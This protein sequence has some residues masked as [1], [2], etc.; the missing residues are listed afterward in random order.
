MKLE[1]SRQIFEKY[2]GIKFNQNP[3]SGS[4]VGPR[5][6]TDE[7]TDRQT[8]M[9]KQIVDFRNF[10]NAPKSGNAIKIHGR[11]HCES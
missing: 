10:A 11:S 4:R 5:E 8:Y 7:S 2:S 6:Q 3:P 1:F 9:A